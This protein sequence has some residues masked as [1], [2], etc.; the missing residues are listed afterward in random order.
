MIVHS[1]E[2]LLFHFVSVSC[3]SKWLLFSKWNIVGYFAL[4]WAFQAFRLI[5]K[6]P[7]DAKKCISIYV[8]CYVI[9][10]TPLLIYKQ[11]LQIKGDI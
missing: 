6:R 7:A 2:F 4:N 8:K 10:K 5:E 3:T 1:A 9:L 11:S